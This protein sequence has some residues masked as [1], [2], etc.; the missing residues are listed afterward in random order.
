MSLRIS[1][2]SCADILITLS[3]MFVKQN[4]MLIL[5][6]DVDWGFHLVAFFS[7]HTHT[8]SSYYGAKATYNCRIRFK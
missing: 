8:R 6:G 4:P 1:M 3:N 5:L 7:D 2:L